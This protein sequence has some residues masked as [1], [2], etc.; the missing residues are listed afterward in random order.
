MTPT[1]CV[2][3]DATADLTYYQTSVSEVYHSPILHHVLLDLKGL[4]PGTTVF[5]S[6]G[7]LGGWAG[8]RWQAPSSILQ[9]HGMQASPA[10]SHPHTH[11]HHPLCPAGDEAHGW[12]EEL[13]FT[14]L[15]PGFP[16]R[17]GI[18]GD[19]GQV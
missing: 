17:L 14:T 3:P 2:P 16:L 10:P 19:M 13:S 12:S 5:Y 15:R 8:K 9:P 4:E 18:V 11:T 7:E 1:H 6:V